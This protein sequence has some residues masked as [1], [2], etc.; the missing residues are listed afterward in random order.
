[1]RLCVLPF[2]LK[3]RKKDLGKPLEELVIPAVCGTQKTGVRIIP[4][5]SR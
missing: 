5:K 2:Y 3:A 1:M 4:E